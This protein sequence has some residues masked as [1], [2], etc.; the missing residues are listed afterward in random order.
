MALRRKAATR[1]TV[2]LPRFGHVRKG[3]LKRLRAGRSRRYEHRGELA[4]GGLG[5]VLRV[6]DRLLRRPLAMKLQP[7][8]GNNGTKEAVS[9]FLREAQVAAQLQHPGVIPILDIGVDERRRLYDTMPLIEGR[10]LRALFDRVHSEPRG[11]S[12]TRA[13]F[14]LVKV[15]EVVGYA[16]SRGVIH[17]DLKPAN[18]LLG[19]FGEI[20]VLDWGLATLDSE[21]LP[22]GVVSGTPSYMAPERADGRVSFQSDVYSLGAMLYRLVAGRSP[23]AP[24]HGREDPA[25]TLELI[26]RGPATPLRRLAPDAPPE[27]LAACERAMAREPEE[28]HASAAE[29]AAELQAFLVGRVAGRPPARAR[30]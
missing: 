26:R 17:G 12:L 13:L 29:L 3:E 24:R 20:Y 30:R 7:S 21:A 5:V 2:L 25:K 22:E 27:L 10:D 11:R 15:C 4:Q 14:A 9:R 16:H 8:E 18:V 28:R 1:R 19:R 6:W 23:Y